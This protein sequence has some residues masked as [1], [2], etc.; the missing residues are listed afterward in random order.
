MDKVDNQKTDIQGKESSLGEDGSVEERKSVSRKET[1]STSGDDVRPSDGNSDDDDDD[2]NE[3]V[4]SKAFIALKFGWNSI[5]VPNQS[6]DDFTGFDEASLDSIIDRTRGLVDKV[7]DKEDT[8]LAEENVTRKL[9]NKEMV[10]SDSSAKI[11]EQQQISVDKFDEKVPLN[12]VYKFHRH[13]EI[14][15]RFKDVQLTS[16]KQ[17]GSLEHSSEALEQVSED[18]ELVKHRKRREVSSRTI[19][20]FVEGLGVVQ[21]MK[22][23]ATEMSV[24]PKQDLNNFTYMRPT[25]K[26]VAGR[27]FDHLDYCQYCLDG[28]EI[29]LCDRCPCSFHLKCLLKHERPVDAKPWSCPHHYCHSCMRKGSQTGFIF[30]CE[31][32]PRA[33]CEDCLPA[34]HKLLTYSERM[35]S[36]GYRPTT[37]SVYIHCSRDCKKTYRDE[38]GKDTAVVGS[39]RK[40][41]EADSEVSDGDI[42]NLE[43]DNGKAQ[44]KI[45]KRQKQLNGNLLIFSSFNAKLST[46][47]TFLVDDD[48]SVE[49]DEYVNA[50]A[51]EPLDSSNQTDVYQRY[52]E[53]CLLPDVSIRLGRDFQT[54][55]SR[56][57]SLIEIPNFVSRWSAIPTTAKALLLHCIRLCNMM[58]E[59]L[60]DTELQETEKNKQSHELS[61]LY[62]FA[63]DT[64]EG[65][66]SLQSMISSDSD[67]LVANYRGLSPFTPL[68]TIHRCFFELVKVFCNGKG[69]DVLAIAKAVGLVST[70]PAFTCNCG[71]T[72]EHT[73]PKFT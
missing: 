52:L 49:S 36:V 59:G 16:H 68:K 9:N 30:R 34:K 71:E 60:S 61:K 6:T 12:P 31:V 14:M 40:S 66:K 5:F 53:S 33:F 17:R 26:Q 3:I 54:A 50:S 64:E 2:E 23:R 22:E 62:D 42:D 4:P 21:M 70:I 15:D 37:A 13:E 24:K 58:M 51:N 32:C 48:R 63:N 67:H 41:K 72:I 25:G 7:T 56:F 20:V 46:N 35:N 57:H 29:V 39:K 69:S 44:K 27:D 1:A 65:I 19:D 18:Y 47:L 8:N 45:S 55:A 73:E 28:G 43:A 10:S 38:F 11:F